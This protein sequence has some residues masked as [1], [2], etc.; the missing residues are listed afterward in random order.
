MAVMS[1]EAGAFDAAVRGDVHARSFPALTYAMRGFTTMGEAV[2]LI[3]FGALAVWRLVAA[4]RRR[5]AV[6]LAL[7]ALGGEALDQALK[8][9]FRRPR[10]QAFFGVAP[11]NYSFPSGHAMVSLCFYLVLAEIVIEEEWPH[12]HRL[13]ARAVAVALSLLVGFS[14]IYLG[15]H[16]PTDVL[17]GYAAAIVW[18]AVLRSVHKWRHVR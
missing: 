9:W 10:P 14:R 5:E 11:D 12:G 16:Y 4:G 3:T 2:F 13:L 6:F 8:E 15:V 1:G 17:A 18:L 7:A